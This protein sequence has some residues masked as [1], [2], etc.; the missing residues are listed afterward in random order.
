MLAPVALVLGGGALLLRPV[1]PALRPLRAGG[2]CVFA[3]VTLALAAGLFGL[4]ASDGPIVASGR[5]RGAAPT[6]RRT[7]AWSGR[8]PTRWR[9]GWS[10][11]GVAILVVFLRSPG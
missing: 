7:G 3:A 10:E 1:L 4:G 6:C 5:A 9:T 11:V 2:L 8:P